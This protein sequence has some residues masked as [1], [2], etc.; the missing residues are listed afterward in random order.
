VEL[1]REDQPEEEEPSLPADP[2]V[3]N[4][5]F[6]LADGHIYFREN[7]R[8]RRVDTSAT[9][10]GRIKGMIQLRDTVRELIEYQ[11]EDYSDEMIREQQRKLNAQYDRFTTQYGLINS[12]ANSLA[13]SDDSSYFLLCSLEIV[14]EEGRLLRKADMFTKRTIRQRTNVEQVDTASEA[15]AV[16]IG[17]KARVDLP[18]MAELTGSTEEQLMEELR[19]VIFPN[20]ENRDETDQPIFE[21]ADAYLSGNVREKLRMA[22]QFAAYD[23][24]RYSENVKALE[25]VQPKDLDASEIDVRLGA[26]W[27]PPEDV[28]QFLFE[29][30]DTPPMYQ[31]YINV[32]YSEYTAAWNVKGKSDDRSNNIKANVTYGTNRVNA[33]KILED[34]LNLR[35]VRIFDTVYEDGVEKRVLNKQETAIAQQKQEMMKEAFRDWIWRDPQRRERLTRLYNDRFNAIRPR[36]YDGS[37]IRFTGMN[38]EIR[39]RQHQINAVARALYGGNSLFAHCVGAGKTFA[40]TAAAMESKHLGLCNKSML[41]VPNHLTEQWAAE[42]LQLYPSANILVATKKDFETKNRKTFCARIA[43]GDYDAIIIGHSQFEKIPIST[44]RQRQQLY[45]QISEITSGIRE[46]KEAKGE[47]YAIKQLEKTKKTLQFKLEKLNDTSRKD[48]VVTFEELGVDRLFVDEAD[49]YKNLFLYT[50]MR[51]VAGLSQT[52]AQKSSDMFAKCRYLDELTEGRGIIFATGTPISNSITEM[53]TMQRYLQYER[54]KRQ[55][56]QHFDAWASTFGETVTAIELAPEG[57][58]YRAKTR[59]ARFYNL[60]ELM[61]VFKEVADIQTADMLQLPVPKAHF[62]NVAVPPSDFQRDMV[63][64]LA[65]RAEQVRA[66]QVEPHEDNMLTITNDG[67]KLALDQRLANPLLPDDEGSKVSA[68]ADNVFRYWSGSREERLTQLVFC[69]LSIP[70]Q[71]GSFNVY[72]ELRRK[73]M[74]RGVPTEEI[75]YIHDANTEVKKKELFAKVRSGQVR[76][77]LGSTFKMGAGTNVQTKLIALHDLDCPWRP[78]DL[79]QR[80]GRIIRQGNQNS[81]VHIFRYV[82]EN[83]FDAYLYQTLEN[84]QRFISQIMTSKSPVRSAEDID[85]TALS[86]AEVKALAT[87]NPYIKE[88][89]DLDIQ[90]SKLKLLKANHLSQRYALEDRLLKM[91]PQQIKST[92][93]RIAGYEQDAALYM[94]SKA[95]K[96]ED[97]EESNFPGMVIKDFTYSERMAAGAALLEACKG[98]TSPDPQAAGSYFGFSMWL[99]FDNFHK[100][101][102]VTLRGALGH[103]VTLGADAGG[104]MTRINNALSDLPAK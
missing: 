7:S 11:T 21:T 35:D 12:R 25:A 85:E 36:E 39:L 88:K 76:V 84:K 96:K 87:G 31:T 100:E 97:T 30:V 9:A 43:T 58:G 20:P 66:K 19:G 18:Y 1:E 67:R 72:D 94:R 46:L 78:R 65:R 53:Y 80:S 13:F 3:R 24:E 57:T 63:A 70:K 47:R 102:K 69:D 16:S 22:R 48:D 54:L 37:H 61:N 92:E 82:T 99:S 101:Y 34:T 74:D 62:H 81:E 51:N 14:D 26:I 15:L 98:M 42:F 32:M 27:L 33:Y 75:A 5:S 83:T 60:P 95:T 44:D 79:E 64:D 73:L 104:N 89:M 77:L 49:S 40:M 59:F 2:S 4:F 93:E 23:A 10:A 56:L 41:V 68:C 103:T 17:A 8:M 28:R 52:E 6:A 29:L 55:G 90:V 45:E 38:P 50:K 91:L 71:D 86:Y